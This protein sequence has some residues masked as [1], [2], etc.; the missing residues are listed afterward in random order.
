MGDSA[1]GS[2]SDVRHLLDAV[3]SEDDKPLYPEVTFALATQPEVFSTIRI[4]QISP[5]TK[6]DSY[7]NLTTEVT[8]RLVE[9]PLM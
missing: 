7:G 4:T 6:L 9:L 1:A 2:E 3:K 8:A 5:T